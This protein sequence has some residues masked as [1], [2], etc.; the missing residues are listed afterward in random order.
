MVERG[1]FLGG[2]RVDAAAL[3]FVHSD[4]DHQ[5]LSSAVCPSTT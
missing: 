4:A 1:A 3:Q 2:H 5:S